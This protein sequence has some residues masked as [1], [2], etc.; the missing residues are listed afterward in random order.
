V[1]GQLAVNLRQTQFDEG[2]AAA[3]GYQVYCLLLLA[4]G[5]VGFRI[6]P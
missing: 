3:L 4:L 2:A 6:I 1:V 5:Y